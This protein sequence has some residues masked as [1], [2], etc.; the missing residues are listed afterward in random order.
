[1]HSQ[2]ITAVNMFPRAFENTIADLQTRSTDSAA[3]LDYWDKVDAI[4]GGIKTMRDGEERYLPKFSDEDSKDYKFR[5]SN[6]KLTNIYQDVVESLASKPFEEEARLLTSE[7]I[8]IPEKL[9][10][11]IEDIDGRGNHL[12]I[13]AAETFFNGINSAIHWIFI[14]YPNLKSEKP[15]TIADAKAQNIRPFWSHVLGRNVLDA[16]SKVINGKEV[17]TYIKI[18]E[19]GSPDH[20]R[21]FTREET[22]KISWKLSE[23][24]FQGGV[25]EWVMVDEG[26]LTIDVIPLVPFMTGRRDGKGYKL[27]PPMQSAAELQIELYQEESALKFAKKL[28]AYPMLAGNGIRPA[29]SADGK[30][31]VKLAVGPGRVLYAPPDGNGAIG[32]WTY[33]EPAATSLKFLAEDIQET[34]RD[35]RELGRQPLTAQSGNLTVITAATAAGKAKTAVGAWAFNLKDALENAFVITCK[36]LMIKETEYSPEVF[37]YTDF[38]NFA[39]GGTDLDALATARENGDLSQETYWNELK[40]RKVLSAEF[41][42]IKEN[43]RIL[44]EIP[45][46][47]AGDDAGT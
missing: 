20:I 25:K 43:E 1:M 33:V 44:N 29:M 17:L 6:T 3:M 19:P 4:L 46:D 8:T 32:N 15:L 22:G 47:D 45:G 21:E 11:M 26:T 13:F 42:A 30:T 36:W 24:K 38:D 41:D 7:E 31:P 23:K 9:T 10:G 16:V 40:R 14:D 2:E 28:A 37:I 12:T 27:F 39:E 34:K 5:L 18:L 35:L